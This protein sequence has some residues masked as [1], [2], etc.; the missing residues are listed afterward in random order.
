MPAFDAVTQDV[1]LE[2]RKDRQQS[3]QG[4]AARRW[5]DSLNETNGTLLHLSRIEL[6]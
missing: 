5:L 2:L 6:S 4:S 1:A 3:C